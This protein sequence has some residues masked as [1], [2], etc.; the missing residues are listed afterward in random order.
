MGLEGKR[1][2]RPVDLLTQRWVVATGR[3]VDV[4]DVPW[5]DGPVGLP[6][7]I[8]DQWIQQHADRVGATVAEP[9][10]A[11]LLSDMAD[12]DGPGF[13]P[14]RLHPAIRDF[15]EH[16]AMWEMDAWAR[17][18]RWAE[19]G[20]RAI[21][22]V[23]SRRLRQL[24]LP[25]DPLDVAHGL[26][27]R[28]VR[29]TAPDGTHLGTAWQRT[30]RATG[31]TAFGGFYGV[32]NLPGADRP[33]VRVVFPLPNGSVTVLLHP[34]VMPDGSLRLLSPP[35]TFGQ[36]G[37]YLVVR[38]ADA[39]TGWARRVPLPEEF[40]VYLDD[41]HDLRCDHRLHLGRAQVLHLHYRLRRMEKD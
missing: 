39:P 6:D 10:D 9:L 16:T 36:D 29:L 12:L 7:G 28:V 11:G 17:W 32:R 26:D 35:G 22:A 19:P 37:A 24:A 25:L 41:R 13:D 38:T 31:A 33:S 23:F 27:S 18:T 40:H 8:G 21:A 1:R 4:R 30:L 20:G 3:Q 14:T 5:L 2:G 15:Y 34:E